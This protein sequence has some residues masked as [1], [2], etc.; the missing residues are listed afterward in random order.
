MSGDLPRGFEPRSFTRFVLPFAYTLKEHRDGS[1]T[2]DVLPRYVKDEPPPPERQLY[3]TG[4]TRQVLFSRAIWLRLKGDGGGFD[5]TW[6]RS[7]G[8]QLDLHRSA[9]RIVLFEYEA[10]KTEPDPMSVGFLLL[11][12]ATKGELTPDD[13]DS[14]L[15]FNQ[16]FRY[17]DQPFEG[18]AA[19]TDLGGSLRSYFEKAEAGGEELGY[20]TDRLYGG[21][22]ESL[23]WS[24][25]NV[26][27]KRFQLDA[28][29]RRDPAHP[30]ASAHPDNSFD[31]SWRRRMMHSSSLIDAGGFRSE[32]VAAFLQARKG[33][34]ANGSS[35]CSEAHRKALLGTSPCAPP[36][37][38]PVARWRTSSRREQRQKRR[39][40]GER[41]R[42]QSA[43]SS[44][45]ANSLRVRLL[46][47]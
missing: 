12:I 36:A 29:I 35:S 38:L 30:T 16:L 21:R 34:Q 1:S 19:Q 4:E 31:M 18:H 13:I 27:R 20:C 6:T 5:F 3:L 45:G 39:T 2:K 9:P 42:L 26:D 8:P 43:S 32:S 28:T 11:D 15:H 33:L 10:S 47:H 25:I 7:T 40:Q 23:L 22:W 24:P 37:C 41:G 14:L 46:G 44:G 17:F